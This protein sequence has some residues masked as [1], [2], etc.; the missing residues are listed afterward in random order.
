MATGYEAP[1]DAVTVE[2]AAKSKGVEGATQAFQAELDEIKNADPTAVD[3]NSYYSSLNAELEQSGIL[4]EMAANWAKENY[5]KLDVDGGGISLSEIS[6]E[7]SNTEKGSKEHAFLL[8][9]KN[10]YKTLNEQDKK[11]GEKEAGEKKNAVGITEKDLNKFI[12]MKGGDRS[13]MDLAAILTDNKNYLFNALDVANNG[14]GGR[15]GKVSRSDIDAFVKDLDSDKDGKIS[16]AELNN[17]ALQGV[18]SEDRR[19][20][21][22]LLKKYADDD[23][24]HSDS[25]EKI[26]KGGKISMDSLAKGLNFEGN[27]AG[28]LEE[29]KKRTGDDP[30]QSNEEQAR[31]KADK[32]LQDRLARER[33]AATA[34]ANEG[35]TPLADYDK[36]MIELV[37]T[38]NKDVV[39]NAGLMDSEGVISKQNLDAFWMG[40]EENPN[41]AAGFDSDTMQALS[42]LSQSWKTVSKDGKTLNINDL[43]PKDFTGS[44]SGSGSEGPGETEN[45]DESESYVV[46]S[47]DSFW[48]IAQSVLGE[49]ASN[50]DI[51]AYM[52]QI[53]ELNKMDLQ[54]IIYR[55]DKLKLPKRPG[56]Q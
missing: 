17:Q 49:G 11:D 29:V 23:Y 5:S 56:A 13:N 9:L 53:A 46:Q 40:L 43:S 18:E 24:W 55:N 42:M 6:I 19:K 32:D 47:G 4:P 44:G 14:S 1:K 52:Q 30:N 38:A 36:E 3:K 21:V 10:N 20:A 54:T 34:K 12:D 41:A 7:L 27:Q 16:D 15:D 2:D 45:P 33:E 8:S 26:Q 31:I 39:T 25:A 48:G 51:Q 28:L 37:L 35:T 22:D 50:A